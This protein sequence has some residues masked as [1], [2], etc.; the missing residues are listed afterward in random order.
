MNDDDEFKNTSIY[1]CIQE[2]IQFHYLN[3]NLSSYMYIHV[4]FPFLNV[5]FRENSQFHFH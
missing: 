3:N 5:Y 2:W 1:V 4:V